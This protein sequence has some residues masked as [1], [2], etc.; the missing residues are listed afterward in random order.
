VQ[1]LD[2][3]VGVA[4]CGNTTAEAK[5]LI[6][7]VKG[8][9]NLFVVQSGQASNNKTS[10][11]EIVDFA[12]DSGLNVI[13]Y[14]GWFDPDQSWRLAWLDFA[15]QRWGSRFSGVYL[16][17]ELG[18]RY[19]DA[20]WTGYFGR[21][22]QRGTPS[23]QAHASAIDEALQGSH[24]QNNDEAAQHFVYTLK[25][26]IGLGELEN[27][28]ITAFTSDYVLFWFDYVGG[29]DVMLSQ[30]GWNQ[31]INQD[32]S[33][34]RGAARMQNK[35]WGAIITWKYNKPP[36]LD[37]GD[38][39]Y[40]QLLTAYNAGAKYGIIF[41]FP[42]LEGNPYGVMTDEHFEALELFWDTIT[43]KPRSSD[44]SIEAEAVLVLPKNYGWGMRHPDDRIWGVWGPDENSAQIWDILHK[45]LSQYGLRLDI[46]YDDP[47]FDVSREYSKIYYWNQTI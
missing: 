14:F 44:D 17:D 43:T 1:E 32:I 8:Y 19:L 9:T 29:Y 11:N 42:Q 30:F 6:D 16:N 23:Y 5:L 10:L 31:S 4:F 7:R 24:P 12:V 35:T 41:N 45:L 37:S 33:L 22:K 25:T 27:R 20:N 39:I 36:Y 38:T 47:L 34:I 2:F 40:N 21:I 13:V 28:T 46:V 15:K 26:S 18:G 3:Q